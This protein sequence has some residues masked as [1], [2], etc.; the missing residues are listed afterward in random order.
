M[1][2]EGFIQLILVLAIMGA[3]AYFVVKKFGPPKL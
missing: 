2:I 3:V 1:T